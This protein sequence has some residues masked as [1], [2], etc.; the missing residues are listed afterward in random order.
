MAATQKEKAVLFAVDRE[1]IP[2]FADQL[3]W[4]ELIT[5]DRSSNM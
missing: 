1:S 5:V 2:E 3:K 4:S